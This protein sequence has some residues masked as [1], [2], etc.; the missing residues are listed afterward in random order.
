MEMEGS[1]MEN[2]IDGYCTVCGE[3]TWFIYDEGDWICRNC[4]ELNTQGN[5]NED[6]SP[7]LVDDEF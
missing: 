6:E 7:V 2:E 4:G 1:G 3:D 5:R